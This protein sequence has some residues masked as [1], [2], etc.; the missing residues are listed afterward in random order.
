[1]ENIELKR[2]WEQVK[3]ELVGALPASAHPWIYPLEISGYDKG[4]LTVVTGQSM[5]RD[6]LKKNH[7]IQM[8]LLY[9]LF[10]FVEL[11]VFLL[12]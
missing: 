3:E 4:V 10:L 11:F 1:M 5:G 12:K 9:F 8:V 2:F 6:W 7:Y